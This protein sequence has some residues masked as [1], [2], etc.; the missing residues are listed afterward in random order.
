M[1][2]DGK[3][4]KIEKEMEMNLTRKGGTEVPVA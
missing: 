4:T 3:E 2:K 1:G